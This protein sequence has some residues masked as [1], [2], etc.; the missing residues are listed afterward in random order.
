MNGIETSA[1]LGA[2]KLLLNG[3]DCD[4]G[5][6][7]EDEDDQNEDEDDGTCCW[8]CSF[9]EIEAKWEA[10][11][12]L[13]DCQFCTWPSMKVASLSGATELPNQR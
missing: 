11:L 7:D 12:L 5:D 9:R 4:Y 13:T 3:A 6:D 8:R 1:Q 10:C 2:F